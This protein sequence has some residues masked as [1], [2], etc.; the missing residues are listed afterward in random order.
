MVKLLLKAFI[1][2]LYSIFMIYKYRIIT[3]IFGKKRCNMSSIVTSEYK[4]ANIL[5]SIVKIRPRRRQ[6]PN[7]LI[8]GVRKF[9]EEL[10]K[11]LEQQGQSLQK[12]QI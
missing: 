11:R 4:D 9:Q 8:E 2:V 7:P 1:H 3:I 12:T 6:G 10:Q 5:G